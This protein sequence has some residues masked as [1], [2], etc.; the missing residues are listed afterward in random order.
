[1]TRLGYDL[2]EG[3]LAPE[4]NREPTLP[5]GALWNLSIGYELGA[6]MHG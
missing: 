1:M 2:P 6:R 3:M 5:L 4:I